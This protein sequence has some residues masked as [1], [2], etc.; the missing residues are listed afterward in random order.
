MF[1]LDGFFINVLNFVIMK[2]LRILAR[3]VGCLLVGIFSI[4]SGRRLGW[5]NVLFYNQRLGK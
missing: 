3:L 2:L 4:K 5:N 1:K